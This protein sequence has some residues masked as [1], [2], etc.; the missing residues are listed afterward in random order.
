MHVMRGNALFRHFLTSNNF[1]LSS[2][3]GMQL[4]VTDRGTSVVLLGT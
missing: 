3:L 1:P 2:A 4:F